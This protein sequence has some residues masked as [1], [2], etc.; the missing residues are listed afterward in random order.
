MSK[1]EKIFLGTVLLYL[2]SMIF[3]FMMYR[4]DE[5]IVHKQ[6]TISYYASKNIQQSVEI[7][8]QRR[9]INNLQDSIDNILSFTP[10]RF[11]FYIDYFGL[12]YPS[13]VYS[14]AILETGDFGSQIFEENNNLFGMKFPITRPTFSTK[15]NLGHAMYSSYICSLKDYRIYQFLYYSKDSTKYS[16]YF[17][18]LKK[19]KYAEDPKYIKKLKSIDRR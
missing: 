15:E 13:L 14:Q 19:R 7:I 8:N 3:V 2:Y 16:D 9:I 6:E 1:L 4:M 11:K 10:E 5:E 17:D 18:F 12:D